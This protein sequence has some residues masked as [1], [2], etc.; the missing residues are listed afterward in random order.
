MKRRRD[1]CLAVA[2]A[3]TSLQMK[4]KEYALAP[5]GFNTARLAEA[6]DDYVRTV[7]NIRR[8]KPTRGE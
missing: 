4:A 5:D 3:L 8:H 7:E 6:A 2:N 1:H